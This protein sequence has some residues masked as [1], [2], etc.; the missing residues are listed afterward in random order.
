MN[1]ALFLSVKL[2]DRVANL[3]RRVEA[4]LAVNRQRQDFLHRFF[5]VR[6]FR[7]VGEQT[8]DRRLQVVRLGIMD[9]GLDGFLLQKFLQ[10]VA[11]L[12][13]D[14]IHVIRRRGPFAH[15]RRL[16]DAFEPGVVTR[17]DFAAVF[18]EAVEVL[19]HHTADGGV[20]FVEP[21]VVAGEFMVVFALAAMVAQHPQPV[22]VIH[23]VC[24]DAA[25]IAEHGEIFRREKAERA[26]I[27]HAADGLA[28]VFRA[29]RLRAIL[30]E[31]QMIFFCHRDELV[32]VHRM[33]VKMHADDADGA[34]RDERFDVRQI[35]DERVV[36]V[37]EH[38]PRAEVDQRLHRR[39]RRVAGHDDFVA[40]PDA[41][42]LV[43]QINNHRPRTAEDGRGRAG[44][45][46][47]F[48]LERLGLGSEDVLTG[49]DGAQRSF[50]DFRVHETFRQRD[51][52]HKLL[53]KPQMDTDETQILLKGH[54]FVFNTLRPK[55]IK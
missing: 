7:N 43:Q 49:A 16:D 36:N 42:N 24:D 48:S 2:R 18:V 25:A 12:G 14:D 6:Q 22:G 33:S 19:Q 31:P 51:F 44:V 9:A 13:A 26:E 35:H 55:F 32:V 5:G 10:V 38:R 54:S 37:R 50:L 34:R 1:L 4:H 23:L 45:R 17:G 8:D 27:A 11:F 20:D 15:R 40:R 41:L 3:V 52:A 29:L 28:L 53:F 30:D 21:D 46:G 39:K 47:E